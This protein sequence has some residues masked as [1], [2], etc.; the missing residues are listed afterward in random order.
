MVNQ[1]GGG[2]F[3]ELRDTCNRCVHWVKDEDNEWVEEWQTPFGR[4]KITPHDVA[5][6]EWDDDVERVLLPHYVGGSAFVKDGSG[7]HTELITAPNHGC[8]MFYGG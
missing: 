8:T 2:C 7:Y 3:L 6:A 1:H 4:C 5:A